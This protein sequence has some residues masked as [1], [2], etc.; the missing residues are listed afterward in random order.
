MSKSIDKELS[1]SQVAIENTLGNKKILQRVTVFGYDAKK[2]KEGKVLRETTMMLQ[3]VQKKEYGLQYKATDALRVAREET[4]EL[5]TRHISIARIVFKNDR[6][7]WN[8][9]QL[10]GLRKRNFTAWLE[11][12]RIFYANAPALV[13]QLEPYGVTLAELESGK[14]M[15]DAV[16]AAY[17]HQKQ[18]KG[19]A[20]QATR[21]R[22][23]ALAALRAWMSDFM[24]IARIALKDDVQQLESLGMVVR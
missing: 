19:K 17:A 5:F 23:E 24:A 14:A 11:K 15:I 12:A 6:E 1:D 4:E 3:T 20:Q 16:A 21:E 13:S 9:L 18:E 8:S 7:A 10:A 22:D 2:M